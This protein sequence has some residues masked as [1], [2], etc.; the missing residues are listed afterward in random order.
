MSG[1]YL[2]PH[3]ENAAG[4]EAVVPGTER[5]GYL[6]GEHRHHTRCR[7][8]LR[9]ALLPFIDFG[10]VPLAGGFH[11][12]GSTAE[13]FA[14]ERLYPLQVCFC[15]TCA[16]VQVNDAIPGE[17][18]FADYFYFSSAIG[19]LVNHFEKYADH[20][21]TVFPEPSQVTLLELGCN[22]GVFLRP[23]R[24]RG[25][26]VIGVD[27]ATNVVSSLIEDGFDVVNDFFG[28][29]VAREILARRG[30]VDGIFSSNAF[31]HIDDMHDVMRGVTTLLKPDGFL[32]FEV[33]YLGAVLR[34]LQYDML[35]HEHFSYYS[36]TSVSNFLAMFG[37]EV[38]DV[39]HTGIHGG[40]VRFLA[41]K[42]D[43]GKRPVT[44]A[45]AEMRRA[46]EEW[47]FADPA[48]YRDFTRRVNQTR[49]DLLRL[50]EQLRA[51]GKRVVGYG[52][53]GRA[54]TL[55]AYCGLT[56]H[57][58]EAV[59]DDAPAKQGAFTPGNHLPIVGSDILRG[60]DRPDYALLF[61]WAFAEEISRRNPE[62]LASGGRFIVPLPDVRV[63]GG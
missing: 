27:P 20:L 59:V 51:E 41:Q 50:L 39:V 43:R 32:A 60:P 22:D 42:R 36:L 3:P 52:A 61:A 38:F 33:H 6:V 46:E 53:S 54:T 21:A 40:S 56:R 5:T 63:I 57:H 62:Y 28:E 44:P 9:E 16:L 45:V 1:P 11:K 17:V 47:G 12:P 24:A 15:T 7:F 19:T 31:A 58:L 18:L 14:R 25:F 2:E 26:N 49:A 30:P 34:E 10:H 35:Y 13:D 8:C 29:R 55:S 37:M 23:L 48:T 4:L